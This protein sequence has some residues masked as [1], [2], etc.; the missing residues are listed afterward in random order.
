MAA[1]TA[2]TLAYYVWLESQEAVLPEGILVAT[3]VLTA[4]QISVS[5]QAAGTVAALLVETGQVVTAGTALARIGLSGGDVLAVT[6]PHGGRV[7]RIAVA[8]GA[9]VDAGQVVVTVTDLADLAMVA[10]FPAGTSIPIGAEAR[11]HFADYRDRPVPARV[12]S[13]AQPD[14]GTAGEPIQGR[15]VT[16]TV[17]VTDTRSLPLKPGQ[18]GRVYLRVREGAPWPSRIR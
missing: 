12:E 4:N 2:A 11:L 8:P 15:T 14:G 18:R 10:P 17:A 5:T 6:A 7:D 9:R 13:V 16:V 1:A 3:G